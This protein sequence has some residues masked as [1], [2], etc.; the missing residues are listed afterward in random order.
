M[1]K[2]E[3]YHVSQILRCLKSHGKAAFLAEAVKKKGDGKIK[4]WGHYPLNLLA[5]HE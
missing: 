1:S 3:L 5:L 4:S 2:G